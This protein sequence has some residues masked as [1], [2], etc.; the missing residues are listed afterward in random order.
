[1]SKL[2]LGRCKFGSVVVVRCCSLR[3][4][5]ALFVS[6]RLTLSCCQ[7]RSIDRWLEQIVLWSFCVLVW[8]MMILTEIL[9]DH[10]PRS[11]FYAPRS[12]VVH[13]R[14]NILVQNVSFDRACYRHL[15]LHFWRREPCLWRGLDRFYN[16]EIIHCTLTLPNLSLAFRA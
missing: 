1:M 4:K 16:W 2:T 12:V 7:D 15:Q 13:V 8:D 9:T 10:C 6:F 14:H 3:N 5:F 11:S